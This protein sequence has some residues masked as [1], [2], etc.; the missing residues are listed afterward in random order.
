MPVGEP[1]LLRWWLACRRMLSAPCNEA[2]PSLALMAML[3]GEEGLPALVLEPSR[4]ARMLRLTLRVVLFP[5][6]FGVL[7]P[8]GSGPFSGMTRD[9]G[10]AW[11]R[12]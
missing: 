1:T 5:E 4:R 11:A 8:E 12:T 9:V 7:S 10:P 6:R 2:D 3:L